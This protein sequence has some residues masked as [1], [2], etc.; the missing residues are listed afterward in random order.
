M[1]NGTVTV[2]ATKKSYIKHFLCPTCVVLSMIWTVL[3]NACWMSSKL[4]FITIDGISKTIS[5]WNERN[6]KGEKVKWRKKAPKWGKAK[7]KE[8]L[9]RDKARMKPGRTN[10]RKI[11]DYMGAR[12]KGT[13]SDRNKGRGRGR[14]RRKQGRQG[15]GQGGRDVRR[16]ERIGQRKKRGIRKSWERL[17]FNATSVTREPFTLKSAGDFASASLL[18]LLCLLA[19]CMRRLMASSD[20]LLDFTK[21]SMHLWL[22][23]MN[24]LQ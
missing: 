9:I 22:K 17:R 8:A 21:A 1:V 12:N 24:K 15:Q 4:G 11:A 2:S 14:E 7:M 16:L 18:S 6:T 10:D 19:A 5:A 20:C 13:K 3:F 23:K